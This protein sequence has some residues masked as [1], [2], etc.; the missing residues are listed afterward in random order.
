MS[1]MNW[2]IGILHVIWIMIDYMEASSRY[3]LLCWLCYANEFVWTMLSW[4]VYFDKKAF[5]KAIG[6]DGVFIKDHVE[7]KKMVL[8][9]I[10][11]FDMVL[12]NG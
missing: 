2:V 7:I 3:S 4:D 8:V 10:Q 5:H 11:L 12:E 1:S 9:F 6:I